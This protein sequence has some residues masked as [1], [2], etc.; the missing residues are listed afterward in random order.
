MSQ[1]DVKSCFKAI[2]VG[3]SKNRS[4]DTYIFIKEENKVVVLSRDYEWSGNIDNKEPE[5]N[6]DIEEINH[7]YIII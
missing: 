5:S 3:Y 6:K 2:F 1:K 7:E 4:S